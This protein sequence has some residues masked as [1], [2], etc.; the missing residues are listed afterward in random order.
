MSGWMDKFYENTQKM[1][2]RATKQR[3]AI[4][5]VV[6]EAKGHQTAEEVLDASRLIDKSVS[7]ATVYRTLKMLQ[8]CGLVNMHHFGD[9]Q[10][11]FEVV[12]SENDHHDHLIC[13][14]CNQITEFVNDKI[15]NLQLEV[16]KAHKFH[17]LHHKM[18]LYGICLECQKYA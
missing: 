8:E 12:S 13:T 6:T 18:E 2:F 5:K 14:S 4:A 17:L 7:L 10:A 3:S 15:E 9:A 11:K 1:G 16:A